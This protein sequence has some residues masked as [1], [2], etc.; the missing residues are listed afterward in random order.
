[1]TRV[2]VD[3]SDTCVHEPNKVLQHVKPSCLKGHCVQQ[4]G[5]SFTFFPM[6]KEN[7]VVV[8]TV[9]NEEGVN[10]QTACQT[11][12]NPPRESI[13]EWVRPEGKS[14]DLHVHWTF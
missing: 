1:M 11:A 9:E 10:F 8:K 7:V 3:L 5:I 13:K 4:G 6:L 14:G 12:T 2:I